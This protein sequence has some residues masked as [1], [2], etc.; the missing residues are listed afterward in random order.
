MLQYEW[1]EILKLK[2]AASVTN[3]KKL[4]SVAWVC[5][6]TPLVDELSAN[7]CGLEGA[8]WSSWRIP[9]AVFS[10]L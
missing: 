3:V 8:I 2:S 5:E 6:R 9:T 4:N 1:T 7:F 10:A